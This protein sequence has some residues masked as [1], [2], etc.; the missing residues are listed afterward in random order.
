MILLL[1]QNPLRVHDLGGFAVEKEVVS[2]LLS[3]ELGVLPDGLRRSN[4]IICT[5]GMVIA[6]RLHVVETT[7]ITLVD[8]FFVNT[9][10][11]ALYLRRWL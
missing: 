11:R 3:G 10:L 9:A 7:A 5:A 2:A 4:E 1:I 6:K 8:A